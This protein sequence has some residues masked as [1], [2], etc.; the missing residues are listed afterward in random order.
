MVEILAALG[1]A[2]CERIRSGWL[3]QPA[4]AVSSLTYVAVGAWLLWR[5]RAS[6]VR[7]GMLIVS[8][9][10]MLAVGVGS[11]AYHGL[12]PSWAHPAHNA[13]IL[14]LALVLAGDHI[15]LLA[16]RRAIAV[17]MKSWRPAAPWLVLAFAGYWAG[18]T[19]SPLCSPSAVWQPHAAWH[20]LSAI[21]LGLAVLGCAQ[22]HQRFGADDLAG[23]S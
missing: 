10:A 19:A 22:H 8:G 3:A 20:A 15:W 18:R 2:D 14:A 21:G 13:S 1:G 7:R 5:S 23:A 6:G 4:N 16:R 17:L 9:V 12:Q 11:F